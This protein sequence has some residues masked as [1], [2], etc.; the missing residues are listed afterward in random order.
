VRWPAPDW[1]AN[2]SFQG[3]WTPP[4]P[5]KHT[6]TRSAENKITKDNAWDTSF[7]AHLGDVIRADVVRTGPERSHEGAGDPASNQ[8]SSG[9][10]N[11]QRASCG[12]EAGVKIYAKRVDWTYDNVYSLMQVSKSATPTGG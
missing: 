10:L 2:S 7:I 1:P 12:L 11:F 9:G 5:H 8:V 3:S 4:S 6:A